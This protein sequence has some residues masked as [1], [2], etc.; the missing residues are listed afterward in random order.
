MSGAPDA[1]RALRV[2][3]ASD[4]HGDLDSLSE[5]F[6]PVDL[7][8]LTGDVFP[9]A[10]F[11][12]PD[13]RERH[14][15]NWFRRHENALRARFGRTPVLAVDGNHDFAPLAELLRAA[16]VDAH[17]VTPAGVTLLGRR[18]AGF[19]NIPRMRGHWAHESTPEELARLVRRTWDA[20]AD[21][22]VTHC[23]PRGVLDLD[24]GHLGNA[25][26]AAA[27]ARGGHGVE[28]HLFGHVHGTAGQ[29]A[30]AWGVRFY[31]GA[32]GAALVELP[33]RPGPPVA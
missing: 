11:G 15:R 22:L 26:L 28:H 21:V 5:V 18:F 25:P 1:A 31:N 20:G 6:W 16:G 9:D 30:E 13:G 8:V 12:D 17:A 32:L 3:H 19:P 29:R 7:W 27:L 23:P 33:P 4:L 24:D 14:A 10:P 2:A